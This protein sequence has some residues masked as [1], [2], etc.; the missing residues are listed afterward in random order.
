MSGKGWV[1]TARGEALDIDDLIA[2]S[3]RPVGTKE[4][5]AE[6]KKR[7][8]PGSKTPINIRGFQPAQGKAHT[9]VLETTEVKKEIPVAPLSS[10][11]D[12]KKANSTADLTGIKVRKRAT[13]KKP[14]GS[15]AD[16]SNALLDDITSSLKAGSPNAVT[17]AEEEDKK[18]IKRSGTK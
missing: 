5:K 1:T 13:T 8:I 12:G 2:K 15:A 7:K 11:N 17:V 16:A 10:Y 6:I 9:P 4:A 3:K 18:Q 14:K